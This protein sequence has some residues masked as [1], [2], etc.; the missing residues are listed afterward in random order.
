MTPS[1]E[2]SDL[3]ALRYSLVLAQMFRRIAA[4]ILMPVERVSFERMAEYHIDD[5]AR[6]I[7]RLIFME[8]G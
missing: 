8:V 1:L 6:I 3:E 2:A 7:S 4:P 5:A